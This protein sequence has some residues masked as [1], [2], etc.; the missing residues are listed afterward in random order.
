MVLI[1]LYLFRSLAIAVYVL[2]GLFTS[3]YILSIVI[4]VV[5]LSMDFWNTRNVCG[6]T[7]VGLRYWNQVD[8]DGESAWVFESRDVRASRR[9]RL[10]RRSQKTDLPRRLSAAVASGQPG[11]L[12]ALL[13]GALCLSGRLGGPLLRLAAQVQRL[14]RLIS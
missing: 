6:R 2:M 3:N 10:G 11:R 7:L 14:V 5:L 8:E 9:P 13:D 1:S 4:V 12:Q